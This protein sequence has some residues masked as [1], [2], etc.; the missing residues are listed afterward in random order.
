[1][2]PVIHLADERHEP[3]ARVFRPARRRP[4]VTTRPAVDRL[5]GRTLLTS[6]FD[7]TWLRSAAALRAASYRPIAEESAFDG[8][9]AFLRAQRLRVNF[10]GHAILKAPAA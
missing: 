3:R 5:E 4:T 6:G 1:M 10:S 9:P 7:P 2:P 8:D